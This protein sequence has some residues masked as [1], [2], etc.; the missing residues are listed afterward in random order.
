MYLNP[1][2][3]TFVLVAILLAFTSAQAQ[4]TGAETPTLG[5]RLGLYAAGALNFNDLSVLTWQV[6]PT[7]NPLFER[8]YNDS[9][10][11]TDGEMGLSFV[12]GG[13]V[14][15]PISD[16]VH[17]TGRLGVNWLNASSSVS[18]PLTQDSTLQH[19]WS[20]SIINLEVMPG[21]EIH[22]FI[23]DVGLYLL[24]GLELGIAMTSS[25]EQFTDLYVNNAYLAQQVTTGPTEIPN[26]TVR[27]AIAVGVGYDINLSKNIWLQPEVS[28][29]ST[30]IRC[31]SYVRHFVEEA[32][33]TG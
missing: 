20:A 6:S 19:A 25:R 22:N 18:Q 15:I 29:R 26:T 14:G 21:V 1:M 24:G 32:S 33:P 31:E 30:T 28:Y 27:A 9:L 4:E 23:D 10:R 17:F 2:K 13:L 5:T 3:R 16:V 8:W 12:G 11:F 7:Q